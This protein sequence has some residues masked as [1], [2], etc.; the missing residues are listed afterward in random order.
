MGNRLMVLLFQSFREVFPG[1][2]C[3]S[4]LVIRRAPDLS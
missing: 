3:K 2:H 1:I 4:G